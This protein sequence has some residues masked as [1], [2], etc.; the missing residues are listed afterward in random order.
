MAKHVQGQ[1]KSTAIKQASLDAAIKTLMY[2]YREIQRKY[3]STIIIAETNSGSGYN[4]HVDI[5]G[6]PIIFRDATAEYGVKAARFLCDKSD[7]AIESLKLKM[8]EDRNTFYYPMDNSE[9]LDNLPEQVA[10]KAGII[11]PSHVRGLVYVDPNGITE[12][13]PLNALIRMTQIMAGFDIVINYPSTTAKRCK[14][15][16]PNESGKY[17]SVSE[18]I[19]SFNKK[20]CFVREPH[21]ANQWTL[22]LLTN[23]D[24]F[25]LS[26]QMR[27]HGF[28]DANSESGKHI[29]AVCDNTHS[30]IQEHCNKTGLLFL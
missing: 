11:N 23:Y 25:A 19:K 6:S 24:R 18:L 5:T 20:R 27:Q 28:R 2:P 21:G 17:L 22:M 15:A 7:V 3:G 14:A 13:F 16:F 4:E 26:T 30:Q 29:V 10:L 8:G 12:G 9:F 1:G